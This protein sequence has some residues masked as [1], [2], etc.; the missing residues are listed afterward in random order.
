MNPDNKISSNPFT[1]KEHISKESNTYSS[2]T[3]EYVT[4]GRKSLYDPSSLNLGAPKKENP[5]RSKRIELLRRTHKTDVKNE[6]NNNIN[7]IN[8]IPDNDSYKSLIKKIAIQ[9]KKRVKL[10]TSKI[11]KV[12]Q[13][14]R[15]LI[16]K[17]AHSIKNTAKNLNFWS[18]YEIKSLR[19]KYDISLFTKE[20]NKV[21]SKKRKYNKEMNDNI[22]LLLDIDDSI[23][24]ADFI[25]QFEK[26]LE[27]NN[28]EILMDT[29]LPSFINEENNYL[30][31]NINFWKKYI[32]Y[33]CWKYKTELTLLNFINFIE[34]FYIW[35]DDEYDSDIF[36]QLIL[37]KIE[38]LF[39][40]NKISD[41]L[42]IHKL[43]NLEDLFSRYKTMNTPHVKEF[44]ISENC[45]CSTC[46][47]MKRRALT[48]KKFPLSKTLLDNE[49]KGFSVNPKLDK[50]SKITDFFRCSIKLRPSKIKT[51]SKFVQY[52]TDKKIVDYFKFLKD[53]DD[54]KDKKNKSASKRKKR[55]TSKK[56]KSKNSKSKKNKNKNVSKKSVNDKVKEI[57]DLLNLEPEKS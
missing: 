55:S 10:P 11:L 50:D 46:Q 26:F 19:D 22:N 3:Y 43:E 7:L 49:S 48:A 42:L 32:N 33:I 44:K 20:T 51:Q 39:D 15:T 45:E 9:L 57:M 6:Y 36:N 8:N 40:R 14:Y 4:K 52:N 28:I 54:Y 16:L 27:K 24:N 23:N 25:N 53:K 41:F 21:S 5:S 18:K 34:Q 12:Y 30:L 1:S 37:E 2:T 29:K 31:S 56:S 35:I 17:I 38:L 13:P 47:E